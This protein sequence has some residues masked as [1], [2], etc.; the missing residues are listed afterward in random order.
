M[1]IGG[2]PFAKKSRGPFKSGTVLIDVH[3][4]ISATVS[5]GVSTTTLVGTPL[6]YTVTLVGTQVGFAVRT[7][8]GF[9][10]WFANEKRLDRLLIISYAY[11][12]A[13]K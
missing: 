1:V 9:N 7:T 5:N 4:T 11:R 6:F 8:T 2:V 10:V 13:S 12:F 3:F